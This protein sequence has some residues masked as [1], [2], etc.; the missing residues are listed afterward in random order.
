MQTIR[1]EAKPFSGD[2]QVFE[3]TVGE[4]QDTTK[5]TVTLSDNYWQKLTDG[6]IDQAELVRRSFEFLLAREPKESILKEFDL[7]LI[8]KYFTEY[9]NEIS[10]IN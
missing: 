1:V 5:H 7:P 10:Q 4:G 6:G 8:Q 3:V 2:K 9:E